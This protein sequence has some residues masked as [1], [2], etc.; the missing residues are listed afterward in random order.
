MSKADRVVF[1]MGKRIYLR[2]HLESD[3]LPMMQGFNDLDGTL[4]FLNSPL[5]KNEAMERVFIAKQ[6]AGGA[7]P[8]DIILA[9]VLKKTDMVIGNMGLHRI[10]WIDRRATTGTAIWEASCREKGYGSEAKKLFLKYAFDT[11]GLN[12]ID[13]T[14]N[15]SNTRSIAYNKKCGYMLEGTMRQAKYA[16]GA[17]EDQVLMSILADDWR[18]Q[19][20]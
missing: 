17:F 9:I 13:S 6:N 19:Q 3:L 14:V 8:A 18:A 1:I 5:P 16:N 15:A 2:P 11:I 20:K 4:R 12:R 7:A 10:H